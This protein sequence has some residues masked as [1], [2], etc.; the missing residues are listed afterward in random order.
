MLIPMNVY[1]A[2]MIFKMESQ[3]APYTFALRMM[4]LWT[5]TCILSATFK[6][7]GSS[8]SAIFLKNPR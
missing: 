8:F 4:C 3:V 6:M 5:C 1:S 7:V 2:S